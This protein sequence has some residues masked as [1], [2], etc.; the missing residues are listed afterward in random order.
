MKYS[1]KHLHRLLATIGIG[2]AITGCGTT[3]NS[4]APTQT[5]IASTTTPAAQSTAT[6]ADLEQAQSALVSF[7]SALQGGR[8]T[9]AS[10]LF[11]GS[12]ADL[13]NFNPMVP[14]DD[15]AQLLGNAC[16]MN[17]FQCL[18]IQNVVQAQAISPTRFAFV[19]E[20]QN[21]DG[22]TFTRPTQSQWPYTV[23]KIGEQFLVQELP[24]YVQ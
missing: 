3:P 6:A 13:T 7:F 5:A 4:G 15:Q 1:A 24:V 10:M 14:V 22:S 23:E 16:T 18:E 12:Y 2:F 21:E 17:G 11:G 8:Y 9:E 19:V 20:F